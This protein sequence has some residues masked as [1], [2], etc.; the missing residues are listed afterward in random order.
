MKIKVGLVSDMLDILY[1][2]WISVYILLELQNRLL[3]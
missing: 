2:R 3:R 1:Q